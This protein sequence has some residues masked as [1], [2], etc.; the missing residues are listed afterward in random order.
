MSNNGTKLRAGIAKVE[1]STQREDKRVNDPLYGKIILF[2][3]GRKRVGIIAL[4]AVAI[5]GICD[6]SDNFKDNLRNRISQAYNLDKTDILINATHTHTAG[7]MLCEENVLIQRLFDAFGEAAGNMVGVKI[8]AGGGYDDAHVI[9]RTLRLKNGNH[10][11]IRQANPCPPDGEV[12]D[13]GPVDPQIGILKVEDEAGRIFAVIYTYSCH[14]LLGVPD[15]SVTANYPGFASA[16]IEDLT[17]AMAIFLQGALGD[18]TEVLYK[19]FH[20]PSDSEPVGISL[21]LNTVKALK[22]IECVPGKIKSVTEEVFFPRR[23]DIPHRIDMLL[24]EQEKLLSSLRG[25]ALNFKSFLPLYIKYNYDREYPSDYSY[26]YMQEEKRGK[27]DL[28]AL[29]KLNVGRIKR[30]LDN[31]HTMEKLARIRDNM[32]TLKKH[33]QINEDEGNR[34]IKTEVTGMRLGDFTIITC[35]AEALIEVSQ[36]LKKRSPFPHTYLVS[37]SNEYYHYAS[38]A[39]YYDKGGYEVSEC[40]MSDKW[41]KI[42]EECTE[43]IFD[44]LK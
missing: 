38:P 5:G 15:G 35:P 41:E 28:K 29:D 3:D 44:K 7:P 34:D 11:T 32:E 36:N 22:D 12:E 26:R 20:R 43:R 6:I 24:E 27:S 9:N 17:G 40:L 10:W 21:G 42:Y 30:Y 2:D 14:P 16:V 1:I 8:G 23:K 19:D 37:P 18:V 33:F 25:M 39:S 31:I 13:L 4:D